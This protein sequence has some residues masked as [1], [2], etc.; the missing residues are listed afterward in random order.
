VAE[1][2]VPDRVAV[3]EYVRHGADSNRGSATNARGQTN[4]TV[5]GMPSCQARLRVVE[6]S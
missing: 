3:D 1:L 4:T 5:L 6:G 2:G